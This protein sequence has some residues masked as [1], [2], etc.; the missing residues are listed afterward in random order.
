MYLLW[1]AG[2]DGRTGKMLG[3]RDFV[4]Y[5]YNIFYNTYFIFSLQNRIDSAFP[6]FSLLWANR[7]STEE[8]RSRSALRFAAFCMEPLTCG[9]QNCQG[10]LWTLVWMHTAQLE[11]ISKL[12]TLCFF[13]S[14]KLYRWGIGRL[15]KGRGLAGSLASDLLYFSVCWCKLLNRWRL[16]TPPHCSRSWSITYCPELTNTLQAALCV[17]CLDNSFCSTHWNWA[18]YLWALS[19]KGLKF[20]KNK[21]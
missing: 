13:F 3:F 19:N 18:W 10:S 11:N 16:S 12:F 15:R 6:S 7:Y 8:T 14:V 9:W 17:H 1:V 4:T 20:S 2:Y 21:N 5:I